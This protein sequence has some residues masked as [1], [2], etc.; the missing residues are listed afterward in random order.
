MLNTALRDAVMRVLPRVTTPAQ[1]AGGE[2][3]SVAKDHR[4]VRGS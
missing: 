2:L 1:Y 3:N 4:Q